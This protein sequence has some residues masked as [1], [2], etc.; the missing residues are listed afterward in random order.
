MSWGHTDAAH[1]EI[2]LCDEESVPRGTMSSCSVPGLAVPSPDSDDVL[3]RSST[4]I[5]ESYPHENIT[6]VREHSP[7]L[8][9][10]ADGELAG[11]SYGEQR[12]STR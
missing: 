2:Q 7:Q 11:S 10:T 12:T 9:V 3:F 6:F 8:S 4:I 1:P 5:A